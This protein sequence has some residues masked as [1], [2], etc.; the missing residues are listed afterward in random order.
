M[1]RNGTGKSSQ[2]QRV[3]SLADNTDTHNRLTA[4]LQAI[5]DKLIPGISTGIRI[6][7]VSQV[8]D[9]SN[10]LL[11]EDGDTS[12]LQHVIHGDKKRTEAMKEFEGAIHYFLCVNRHSIQSSM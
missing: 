11:S 4:L 1:G 9:T 12:V 7:L 3:Y 2:S 10:A 5:A 8:Q 6:L